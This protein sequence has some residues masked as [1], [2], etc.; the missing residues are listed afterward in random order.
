MKREE[1]KAVVMEI[2]EDLL[3]DDSIEITEETSR[4]TCEEWDSLFHMALMASIGE[5]LSIQ[6]KT[7]DIV[8]A[9]DLGSIISLAEALVK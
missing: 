2:F 3:D 8:G 5:E 7:E 6:F 9:H 1:I 4:E